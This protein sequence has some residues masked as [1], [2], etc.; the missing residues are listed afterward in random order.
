PD[1]GIE[2]VNRGYQPG[3]N[4]GQWKQSTGKAYF[5]A[6]PTTA[7]LKVSFF[8]PFYAS[9][10]VIDLDPDYQHALVCGPDRSYLW[11]LP[12]NPVIDAAT[13]QRLLARAQALGFDTAS[14]VWVSHDQAARA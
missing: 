13:R 4:G 12:R 1:G 6:W 3:P 5:V 11:L 8:G 14:L 2:V 9:Y 10:I 7:H